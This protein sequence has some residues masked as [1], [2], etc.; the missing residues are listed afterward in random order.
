MKGVHIFVLEDD[1]LVGEQVVYTLEAEGFEVTWSK[2]IEETIE[3]FH[4]KSFDLG[5]FDVNIGQDNSISFFSQLKKDNFEMPVI[6]LSANG[7]T[8]NVVAALKLGANDFI[9]KPIDNAELI[10]RIGVHLRL[11]KIENR[12]IFEGVELNESENSVLYD[13]K[14]VSINSRQTSILKLF[15]ERRNEL[16]T[17]EDLVSLF[18]LE[19]DFDVRTIDSHI[20]Q[21]RKKLREKEIR[22]ISI[23]SVYGAGYR[24]SAEKD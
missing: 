14:L 19:S 9:H 13:G 2:S 17:R 20:S 12:M 3:S 4:S 22:H 5:I 24:L 21:L 6:F 8:E 11:L 18:E 15:F 1:P 16:V 7:S 10:A 23:S